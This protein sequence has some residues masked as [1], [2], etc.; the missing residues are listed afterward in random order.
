MAK[1]PAALARELDGRDTAPLGEGGL[2]RFQQISMAPGISKN[3]RMLVMEDGRC[4]VARNDGSRP[5]D[6]QAIYNVPVP[7][8]PT[9]TLPEEAVAAIRAKL[10]EVA[11]FTQ[12]SYV[13]QTGV[14]DGSLSIVTAR[15]G[16]NEHEVWYMRTGNALTDLLHEIADATSEQ[17]SWADLLEE[18][19]TLR[20]RLEDR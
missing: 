1:V 5:E 3:F 6:R 20:S 19:M 12:E 15:R 16:G 8:E 4:Y 2:V 18:Q 14:K 10:D 7:Q 13:E 9:M 11:F 17:S